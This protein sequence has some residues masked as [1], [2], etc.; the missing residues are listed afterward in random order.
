MGNLERTELYRWQKHFCDMANIFVCCV[1]GNN[2]PL[3]ELGGNVYQEHKDEYE[4][5]HGVKLEK[6]DHI[7]YPLYIQNQTAKRYLQIV[8][9][10]AVSGKLAQAKNALN[11]LETVTAQASAMKDVKAQAFF[12]KDSVKSAM[13]ELRAP[14]DQLEMMVDKEMWPMPSYGDLMFEV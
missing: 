2:N 1:D 6:V 9:K 4:Q 11:R 12:Y 3:T 13:D 14:V 7:T 5:A 10:D 8:K